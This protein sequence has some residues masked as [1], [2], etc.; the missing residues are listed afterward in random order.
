MKKCW[1]TTGTFNWENF[2]LPSGKFCLDYCHWFLVLRTKIDNYKNEL[3]KLERHMYP[4][5]TTRQDS[6]S[7]TMETEE[8]E[9]NQQSEYL[10][11]VFET[12]K[13]A[14]GNFHHHLS[15]S[16]TKIRL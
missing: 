11:K 8:T 14:T 15:I 2:G 6:Q 10:E 1:R 3:E 4:A 12:L 7:D 16:E 9:V 5:K 13:E